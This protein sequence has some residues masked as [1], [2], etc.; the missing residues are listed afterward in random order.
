MS[1]LDLLKPTEIM[2]L[3]IYNQAVMIESQFGEM[4]EPAKKGIYRIGEVRPCI[5]LTKTYYTQKT[6]VEMGITVSRAT[7]I[8]DFNSVKDT[9]IDE[10]GNI[11]IHSGIMANKNR[12]LSNTPTVPSRGILIIEFL[13]NIFIDSFSN[14]GKYS[15]SHKNKILSMVKPEYRSI[16]EDGVLENL[17]E[18]LFVQISN[19][20]KNDVKHIYFVKLTGI[21]LLIEK[22]IDFRIYEWEL[23]H[24][25]E[26]R[27]E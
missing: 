3:S 9:V 7:Q 27:E 26:C 14:R 4:L 24:N 11:I 8:T 17:C 18:S 22:T 20:I 16:V 13:V 5:D 6:V 12:Y 19:F 25:P 23:Q 1:I 21:D 2:I 15:A 10:N